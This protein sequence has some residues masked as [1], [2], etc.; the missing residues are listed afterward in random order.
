MGQVQVEGGIQPFVGVVA[1]NAENRGG[2][3]LQAFYFQLVTLSEQI[4]ALIDKLGAGLP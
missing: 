2:D 1:D 3:F 4:D